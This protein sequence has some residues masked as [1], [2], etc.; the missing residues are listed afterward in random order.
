MEKRI[1]VTVGYKIVEDGKPTRYFAD[2]TGEGM[3]YKDLDAY[4]NDDDI[5]YI[6]ECDFDGEGWSVEYREG[7]G[8]TKEEI[9]N[10][11]ADEIRW[12]YEG[13]PACKE[14]CV[15]EAECIINEAEWESVGVI[16]DRIDLAED[17]EQWQSSK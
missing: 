1:D 5:C 12:G 14:F 2:D 9:I 4:K 6:P 17:W 8:Y 13:I 15:H 10:F 3:C 11:V 7:L 16:L